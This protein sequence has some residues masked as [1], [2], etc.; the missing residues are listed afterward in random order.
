MAKARLNSLG[1]RLQSNPEV[2][3]NYRQKVDTMLKEGHVTEVSDP[4]DSAVLGK[5]F[6]IPHHNIASKKFRVVIDCA[7]PFQGVSLNSVLL[8]GPDNL[9]SLLGVLFRFR[10][11]PVAIVADIKNMFRQVKCDPADRSALRF[12]FWEDG[13]PEKRINSDRV[14]QTIPEAD[15]A[16]KSDSL[17][18]PTHNPDARAHVYCGQ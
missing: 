1:K 16:V 14:L 2:K 9:S 3:E 5:T 15:R 12:P 4:S 18:L 6:Y 10:F 7:A 11:Y 13:D 8:Q 17:H